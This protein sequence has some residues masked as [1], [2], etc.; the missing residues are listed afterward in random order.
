MHFTGLQDKNEVD[1]VECKGKRY[2]IGFTNGAFVAMFGNIVED[3]IYLC[4]WASHWE[5]VGNKY[6]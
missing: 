1:I 2:T 3:W 5:I 6:N 4:S